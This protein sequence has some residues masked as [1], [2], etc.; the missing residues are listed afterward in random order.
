MIHLYASAVLPVTI[1][2]A[3]AV[4][5][6]FDGLPAW[7]PMIRDSRVEDGRPP[8]SVGCVRHFHTHG[9]ELIREQLLELS[10]H[11]HCLVYSILESHMGVTDYVA[12]MQLRPITD[13]DGCF[14]E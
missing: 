6:D 7:H 1:D 3:W 10:D 8:D 14:A 4:M 11:R 2:R 13:S 9:G 5:R 12:T